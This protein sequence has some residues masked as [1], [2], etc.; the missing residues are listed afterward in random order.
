MI[1]YK[2]LGKGTS[3]TIKIDD[4]LRDIP[5]SWRQMESLCEILS[6]YVNDEQTKRP[7]EEARELQCYLVVEWHKKDKMKDERPD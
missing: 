4:A 7:R 2:V 3:E 1:S 5:L 6:G